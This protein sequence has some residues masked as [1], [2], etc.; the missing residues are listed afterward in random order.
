MTK[1]MY[2]DIVATNILSFDLV[3]RKRKHEMI[4]SNVAEFILEILDIDGQG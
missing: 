4:C 2:L 3:N 1:L